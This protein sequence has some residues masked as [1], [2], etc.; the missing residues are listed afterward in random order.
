MIHFNELYITEDNKNLIIDVEIDDDPQYEDCY[1]TDIVVDKGSSC[2]NG[3]LFKNPAIIWEDPE[4]IVIG[5]I[6]GDG[7]LTDTDRTLLRFMNDFGS[8]SLRKGSHSQY[9]TDVKKLYYNNTSKKYYYFTNLEEDPIEVKTDEDDYAIGEQMYRLCREIAIC[10]KDSILSESNDDPALFTSGKLLSF[11]TKDFKDWV[12][13]AISGKYSNVSGDINGDGEVSIADLDTLVNYILSTDPASQTCN[14]D[15]NPV[16]IH[17]ER[18]VRLCIQAIH[19]G[20]LRLLPKDKLND[21]FFVKATAS[22]P[23]ETLVNTECG[24]KPNKVVGAAYNSKPL[25]DAAVNN[26]DNLGDECDNNSLNSFIDWLLRYYGFK[27]ALKC[28]QLCRAYRQWTYL[29]GG[30]NISR[31]TSSFRPC[32]CHGTYR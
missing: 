13:Y 1:I 19:L 8:G 11:L 23:T 31:T 3:G 20:E 17:H 15:I 21:I 32:G 10:Y 6:D 29:Q 26:A 24:C 7:V 14:P 12:Y 5:D 18:R 22:C 27:F 28:G 2:D 4:P 25:Y 16:T 30:V 9:E